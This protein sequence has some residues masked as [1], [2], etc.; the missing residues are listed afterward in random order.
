MAKVKVHVENVTAIGPLFEVRPDMMETSAATFPGLRERIDITYGADGKDFA[1]NIADADVLFGWEFPK[2]ELPGMAPKLRWIQLMGAGVEHVLPLDWLP[3]RIVLTNARGAHK[4]KIGEALMLELL[5]LN[6]RIPTLVQQQQRREWKQLFATGIAGKTLLVVGFGE[7]GSCA[8][9]FAK[10]F[11]MKVIGTAGTKKSHPAAAALYPPEKLWEILPQADFILCTVPMTPKTKGIIG[12]A[13]LARC[14]RGVGIV[15]I[16]RHGVI[17]EAA[18]VDA[19]E[20][21]QVGGACYDL[22]D[23]GSVKM[24]ERMWTAPNL[25]IIPHCLSN[26]PNVFVPNVID[27][28][29]ANL[30]CFVDGKKLEQIVRPEVGY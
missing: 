7:S 19:L 22:E 18:L 8:A 5:M 23:P 25:M 3:E 13:E 30:A 10:K 17:D 1:K 16:G 15:S 12:K 26:D 4:P 9:E 28:L 6:N 20:S 27:I 21:G 11:G 14:K 29:M 24:E 2:K